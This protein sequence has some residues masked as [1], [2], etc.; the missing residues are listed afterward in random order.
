MRRQEIRAKMLKRV[1]KTLDERLRET[2]IEDLIDDDD[3]EAFMWEVSYGEN[4]VN[5]FLDE[6]MHD[7][8]VNY[9][10]DLF[11]EIDTS[12]LEVKI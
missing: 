4:L 8:K 12:E 9:L 10:E 6:E 7:I 3:I 11:D 5:E 1:Q 2:S